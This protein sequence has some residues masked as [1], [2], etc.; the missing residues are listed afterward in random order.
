MCDVRIIPADANF[1]ATSAPTTLGT[2]YEELCTSNKPLPRYFQETT[3]V[4]WDEF[5]ESPVA[6]LLTTYANYCAQKK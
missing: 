4:P 6:E 5:K 1:F 2:W 3:L